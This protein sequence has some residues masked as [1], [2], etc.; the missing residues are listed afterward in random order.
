MRCSRPHRTWHS[1]VSAVAVV[2]IVAADAGPTS[3]VGIDTATTTTSAIRCGGRTATIV[4]TTANDILTGTPGDDVIVAFGGHDRID[5]GA[6]DDYVCAG[7]G[8]D[9]IDAGPGADRIFGAAGNDTIDGG[10]GAD[11]I[12]GQSGSDHLFGARGNDD[13]YGGPGD[14]TVRG[15]RGGDILDGGTGD[16]RLTGGRGLD[17]FAPGEADDCGDQ[18]AREWCSNGA[19]LGV[20][21]RSSGLLGTSGAVITVRVETEVSTGLQPVEVAATVDAILGDERGWT[22]AGHR[23]TRI[24]GVADVRLVVASPATVDANCAPL[25][26][27]GWLSCRRGSTLWLNANRWTDAIDHWT[28]PVAEYRAYLVNHELGH[29]LGFGH[30]SCP[31]AGAPAPVMQQQTKSLRGCQPN[32]WIAP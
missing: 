1:I 28:A 16:D 29:F 6:G 11:L 22:S 30:V 13:L 17:L 31:A 14:D 24:T 9:L 7:A 20:A 27:N 23:F 15:G 26:T 5:A 18:Q 4:G 25:R 12:R 32:G 8:H 3:A 21:P 19:G 10:S 2:A